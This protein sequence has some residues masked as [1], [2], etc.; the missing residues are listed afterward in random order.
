VRE[1]HVVAT[2]LPLHVGRTT[3][4]VETDFTMPTACTSPG[5]GTPFSSPTCAGTSSPSRSYSRSAF[6]ESH[7][8]RENSPIPTS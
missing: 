4:I 3:I 7:D 2:S 1:G 5:S 6:G 8:R